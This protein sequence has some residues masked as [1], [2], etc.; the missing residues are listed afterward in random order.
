MVL[1]V[2]TTAGVLIMMNIQRRD[3]SR[4]SEVKGAERADAAKASG[5]PVNGGSA[6]N[7]RRG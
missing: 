6:L 1:T 2:V 3:A 7:G 4:I 5:N